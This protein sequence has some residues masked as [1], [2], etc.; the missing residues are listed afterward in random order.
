MRVP[1]TFHCPPNNVNSFERLSKSSWGESTKAS[2][3]TY[4]NRLP[5]S[6]EPQAS[7]IW[8]PYQPGNLRLT[9]CLPVVVEEMASCHT[10]DGSGR[11]V[12]SDRNIQVP[13]NTC[14]GLRL[15]TM[16]S[17]W[18]G[19]DMEGVAFVL[20][21]W[22]VNRTSLSIQAWSLCSP[23]GLW[24]E[25]RCENIT[26]DD[27]LSV[28]STIVQPSIGERVQ[29]FVS[30]FPTSLAAVP[31]SSCLDVCWTCS[32]TQLVSVSLLLL[33]LL[34]RCSMGDRLVRWR[35]VGGLWIDSHMFLVWYG[36]NLQ[37]QS[38]NFS[39]EIS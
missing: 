37:H 2:G 10:E 5:W 14:N 20:A 16:L 26:A 21:T 17:Q 29:S 35:S 15:E 7:I 30:I 34:V 22:R 24:D 33:R 11:G 8:S 25:E 12:K 1:S 31:A 28:Y 9:S 38:K 19:C 18:S 39:E 13:S 27:C 36:R 4:E 23:E 3:K 32:T 6:N